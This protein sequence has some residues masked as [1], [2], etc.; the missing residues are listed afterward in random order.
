MFAKN[1]EHV[2]AEALGKSDVSPIDLAISPSGL[3]PCEVTGDSRVVAQTEL[4]R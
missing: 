2:I 3:S 4:H 1:L